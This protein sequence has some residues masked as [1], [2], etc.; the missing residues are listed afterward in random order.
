MAEAGETTVELVVQAGNLSRGPKK[1]QP[2]PWEV[3]QEW[4]VK[5]SAQLTAER[6]VARIASV[7]PLLSSSL[8]CLSLSRSRSLSFSRAAA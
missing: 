6:W 2:G 8:V 7:S 1:G 3:T 4:K 5:V